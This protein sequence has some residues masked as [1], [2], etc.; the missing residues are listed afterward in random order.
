MSAALPSP[1]LPGTSPPAPE[2]SAQRLR[3]VNWIFSACSTARVLAYLPNLVSIWQSGNSD[4]H[5]MSTWVIL[6]ASN[7]ATAWYLQET[8]PGRRCRVVW[9]SL[10]NT[11]QCLLTLA[12]IAWY[13][14]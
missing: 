5:A 13:R 4:Q 3:W 12:V 10:A 7:A 11:A 8:N 1:R 9:V 6:A 14:F 2:R